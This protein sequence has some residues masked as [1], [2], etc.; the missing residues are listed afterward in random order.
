MDE[1]W[2]RQVEHAIDTFEEDDR[3]IELKVR[4]SEFFHSFRSP[5]LAEVVGC[6]AA[7]TSATILRTGRL[8]LG[9]AG[10]GASDGGRG[11]PLL[12]DNGRL[13]PVDNNALGRRTLGLGRTPHRGC[14]G[15]TCPRAV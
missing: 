1:G 9:G 6:V 10:S 15:R 7:M 5:I 12:A 2:I 13:D 3:L 11:K 4:N 8:R 14:E